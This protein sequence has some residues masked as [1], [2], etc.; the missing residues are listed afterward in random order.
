VSAP[1]RPAQVA[2]APWCVVRG[3]RHRFGWDHTDEIEAWRTCQR[4]V[5]HARDLE[6]GAIEVGVVQP[7]YRR[8]CDAVE[9]SPPSVL[10]AAFRSYLAPA[11]ARRLGALLIRAADLAE[12]NRP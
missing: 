9:I 10:L 11:A 6:G 7:Q 12:G 5:G 3:H 8:G 1:T 2:C 4:R